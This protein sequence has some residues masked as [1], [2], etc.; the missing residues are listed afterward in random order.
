MFSEKCAHLTKDYGFGDR[1]S[2][3]GAN[4]ENISE[5]GRGSGTGQ[6]GRTPLWPRQRTV[7]MPSPREATWRAVDSD[8]GALIRGTCLIPVGHETMGHRSKVL[9]PQ[10][11]RAKTCSPCILVVFTA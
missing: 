6:R 4:V 5:C 1:V 11:R 8:A 2:I 9:Y 3:L 10:S 7:L